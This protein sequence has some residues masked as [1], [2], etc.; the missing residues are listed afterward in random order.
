GAQAREGSVFDG[1][2]YPLSRT[3]MSRACDDKRRRNVGRARA[4]SFECFLH[5]S[6]HGYSRTPC[7]RRGGSIS[8]KQIQVNGQR[9]NDS[10]DYVRFCTDKLFRTSARRPARV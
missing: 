10:P 6:A 4:P 2:A 5:L 3:L 1:C 7:P 9:E 8:A